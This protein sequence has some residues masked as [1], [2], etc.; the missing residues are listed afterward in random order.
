MDHGV[1]VG[2]VLDR[3]GADVADDLHVSRRIG[4]RT[5]DAGVEVADVE[6]DDVMAPRL[7]HAGQHRPDEALVSSDEDADGLVLA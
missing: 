4:V 1:D 5:A 6:A 3:D 7:R 2:E